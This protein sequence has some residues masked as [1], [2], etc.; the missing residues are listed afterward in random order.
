[1]AYDPECL[2]D[3]C[4]KMRREDMEEML[5]RAS[6]LF[7]AFIKPHLRA[8]FP[9]EGEEK[10]IHRMADEMGMA[11]GILSDEFDEEDDGGDDGGGDPV[12]SPADEFANEL[13]REAHRLAS[14]NVIPF[15]K[16]MR[17]AS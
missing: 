12:L 7:T 3:S 9:A 15:R 2:C 13:D 4:V 1:M 11:A 8:D 17:K 5:G 14:P 16:K 10:I 6:E